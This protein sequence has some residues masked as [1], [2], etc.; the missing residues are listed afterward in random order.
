MWILNFLPFW[1]FH[2]ITLLG[3][4]GLVAGFVLGMIPIINKYKLPIQ[5]FSLL[6]LVFGIYM[7]GAISNEEKW[8]ALVKEMEAKVALAEEKSKNANSKIEYKFLDKVK[9]VEK[10]QVVIQEKLKEVEKVIDAKCEID[11]SV[12]S[13]LN[14]AAKAPK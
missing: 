2:L 14:E 12:I 9:L 11:P 7:E 5:I 4:V 8:Q 6:L 3:V 10:T 1:F 13:I